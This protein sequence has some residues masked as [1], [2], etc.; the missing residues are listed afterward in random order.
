MLASPA[1]ESKHP[2]YSRISFLNFSRFR[3]RSTDAALPGFWNK[4]SG[5]KGNRDF[6]KN[7][8]QHMALSRQRLVTLVHGEM[9][10]VR[11]VCR[12]AVCGLACLM[13]G[14][15]SP[16]PTRHVQPSPPLNVAHSH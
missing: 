15:S 3:H 4:F 8:M 11:M 6:D 16:T 9:E 7:Y 14:R 5:K 13:T 10:T 12:M 1:Y 2:W